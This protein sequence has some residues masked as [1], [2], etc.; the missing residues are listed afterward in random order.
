MSAQVIHICSF[1]VG[2]YTVKSPSCKQGLDFEDTD[3]FG[4]SRVNMR[5][6]DVSPI[7]DRHWFW[8]FYKPWREAGRPTA[9]APISTPCG[10]L[11]RAVWANEEARGG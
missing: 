9:G 3:Q 2:C 4:P 10:E 7:P 5:T 11:Q 8:R 6:G 1:T